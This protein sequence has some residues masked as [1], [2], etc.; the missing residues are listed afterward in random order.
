LEPNL[1]HFISERLRGLAGRTF[2]DVGANVG[3]FTL[4]AALAMPNG[5]VLSIEAFPSIFNKLE[6]NIALNGVDNI[7]TVQCAAM[8]AD[9]EVSMFYQP[10]SEGHTTSVPGRFTT[11][12]VKV[13]GRALA[14]LLSD[15]DVCTL[16]IMK[17]DV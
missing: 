8:G 7:R 2:V 12:A 10:D 16:R 6:G 5:N 15:K 14:D 1:T 9:C 4:L 13:A 11:T 17:I 3:Y